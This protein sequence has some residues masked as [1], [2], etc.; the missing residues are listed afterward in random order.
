MRRVCRWF[1]LA[2][3]Y[4]QSICKDS[5]T[6]A[7]SLTRASFPTLLVWAPALHQPSAEG[8]L[9][10]G[11]PAAEFKVS[12]I[13]TVRPYEASIWGTADLGCKMVICEWSVPAT[14]PTPQHVCQL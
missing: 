1:P 13:R 9:Q 14:S 10:I 2:V 11:K 8:M 6:E 3:D 4:Q 12:L 7:F 5:A